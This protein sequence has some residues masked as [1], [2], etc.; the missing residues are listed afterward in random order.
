[1]SWSRK[2][3]MAEAWPGPNGVV[4]EPSAKGKVRSR[5]RSVW[6]SVLRVR[7]FVDDPGKNLRNDD[8]Q[9]RLSFSDLRDGCSPPRSF[10]MHGL[11]ID[12]GKG[13]YGLGAGEN[14]P[15]GWRY[16]CH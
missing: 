8:T 12:G 4:E 15:D 9:G 5:N 2:S 7:D 11:C 6:P 10:R 1:M 16:Q 3:W 13:C 14:S